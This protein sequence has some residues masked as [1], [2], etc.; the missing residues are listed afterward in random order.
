VLYVL[1][2]LRYKLVD[3]LGQGVA[4]AVLRHYGEPSRVGS[5]K[6]IRT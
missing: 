4:V 3:G 2:E 1:S 5:E 6:L